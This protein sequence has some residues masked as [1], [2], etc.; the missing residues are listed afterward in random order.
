MIGSPVKGKNHGM[1]DGV[2]VPYLSPLSQY[3]AR[4]LFFQPNKYLEYMTDQ[5]S[6]GLIASPNTWG[7]GLTAVSNKRS[8]VNVSNM[9]TVIVSQQLPPDKFGNYTP[10]LLSYQ[11]PLVGR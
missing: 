11:I 2:V 7:R 4:T 3:G 9:P 8:E 10:R 6:R 5:G 1:P